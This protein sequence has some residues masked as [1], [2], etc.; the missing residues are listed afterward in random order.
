MIKRL[1]FVFYSESGLA[2]VRLYD[3]R[4]GELLKEIPPQAPWASDKPAQADQP[5]STPGSAAKEGQ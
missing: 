3:A 1:S 2:M 4:T 5:G